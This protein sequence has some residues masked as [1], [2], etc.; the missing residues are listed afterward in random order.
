MNTFAR[1]QNQNECHRCK[2]FRR[3]PHLPELTRPKVGITTPP[4][5]WDGS[6]VV[7][8]ITTAQLAAILNNSGGFTRGD[9]L[10]SLS[11]LTSP[12]STPPSTRPP[13]PASIP[14]VPTHTRTAA[15]PS[16]QEQTR[17]PKSQGRRQR[18]AK[19]AAGLGTALPTLKVDRSTPP[20]SP[21]SSV[22]EGKRKQRFKSQSRRQRKV[23]RAAHQDTAFGDAPLPPGAHE[24]YF[25]AAEA[26]Y[27]SWDT[28]REAEVT[29]TGFTSQDFARKDAP[30]DWTRTYRLGELVG[31]DSNYKLRLQEWDGKYVIIL[32]EFLVCPDS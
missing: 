10:F 25:G 2:F 26:A 12:E 11:P 8:P 14:I 28:A 27:T 1:I 24:K 20:Q 22:G 32:N 9:D 30:L 16:Q 17:K 15:D 13:S 5:P 18:S 19:G 4:R 21:A 31:P 29:S 3:C 23:Q 6:H 7:V